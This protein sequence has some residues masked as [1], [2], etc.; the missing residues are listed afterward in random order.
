VWRTKNL[1]IGSHGMT[2]YIISGERL[3]GLEVLYGIAHETC[4]E[5]RSNPLSA[6]LGKF[7]HDRCR[8]RKTECIDYKSELCSPWKCDHY[9]KIRLQKEHE[10]VMSELRKNVMRLYDEGFKTPLATFEA[11]VSLYKYGDTKIR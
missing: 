8:C 3:A 6:G 11:A 2:D 7:I 4:D 1:I 10:I 5:I 9:L